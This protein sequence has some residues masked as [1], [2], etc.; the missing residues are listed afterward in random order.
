M[1]LRPFVLA[2][3]QGLSPGTH[4]A[5]N[6]DPIHMSKIQTWIKARRGSARDWNRGIGR[7]RPK[8]RT[9]TSTDYKRMWNLQRCP[10]WLLKS[11]TVSF[12]SFPKLCNGDELHS[13]TRTM[14]EH[15]EAAATSDENRVN[16]L[17]P[18]VWTLTKLLNKS[19]FPQPR[20]VIQIPRRPTGLSGTSK[21]ILL[22][23]FCKLYL[24]LKS[25]HHIIT[26]LFITL[27]TS[28]QCLMAQ[29]HVKSAK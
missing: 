4:M 13:L 29:F 3:D 10:V 16:C 28:V 23:M 12:D 18:P 14:L 25:T 1:Q 24:F 20:K 21:W 19:K 22:C 7:T 5:S 9:K 15:N 27:M 17:L 8:N 26:K 11:S 2:E 6:N